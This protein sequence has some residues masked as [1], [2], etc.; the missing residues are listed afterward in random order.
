MGA[1]FRRLGDCG[2]GEP[3]DCLMSESDGQ[4]EDGLRSDEDLV[5]AWLRY[6]EVQG[7]ANFDDPDYWAEQ[8][9]QDLILDNDL[10]EAWRLLSLIVDRATT[11]WQLVMVGCGH[12]E[13][14]LNDAPETYMERL[15]S[16]VHTQRN[17]LTAAASVWNTPAK[18]RI[19]D[20]LQRY[21]QQR[22]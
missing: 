1:P 7:D 9:L 18:S 5:T 3:Y 4:T 17:W 16:S 11:E 15:E 22:L 21:G 20:L 12:L 19:D 8:R 10:E 14:L 13:D 6:N 2:E